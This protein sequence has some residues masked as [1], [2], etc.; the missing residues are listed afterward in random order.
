MEAK[1][2][3]VRLA[4][5]EDIAAYP[6][7]IPLNQPV[8]NP[9]VKQNMTT[10]GT[11]GILT[12]LPVVP[13]RV[14]Q[15][16]TLDAEKEKKDELDILYSK[17]RSNN[18]ADIVK[19]IMDIICSR[20]K[21]KNGLIQNAVMKKRINRSGRAVI[22]PDPCISTQE[23]IIPMYF[24]VHLIVQDGDR[25]RSLRNGDMVFLNRQP[26]LHLGNL[27]AFKVILRNQNVISINPLCC[28]SFNADFDGD[29]MNIFAISKTLTSRIEMYNCLCCKPH[30]LQDLLLA[31]YLYGTSDYKVITEHGFTVTCNRQHFETMVKSGAKG[32]QQ[33]LDRIFDKHG[34][35]NGIPDDKFLKEAVT[36]RVALV[37]SK[38]Q[39]SKPGYLY[40]EMCYFLKDII[41]Q[42][43]NTTRL[44]NRLI[45]FS[46]DGYEPG[47]RVGT[48]AATGICEPATQLTLNTFHRAGMMN[49]EA[50]TI[51]RLSEVVEC[52]KPKKPWTICDN[53]FKLQNKSTEYKIIQDV[54]VQ[55]STIRY[56]SIRYTSIKVTLALRLETRIDITKQDNMELKKNKYIKLQLSTIRYPFVKV[57]VILTVD[58][59]TSGPEQEQVNIQM[60][61]L[62]INNNII[63]AKSSLPF[64]TIQVYVKQ[65]MRQQESQIFFEEN[66]VDKDTTIYHHNLLLK[67]NGKDVNLQ[68]LIYLIDSNDIANVCKCFG[69][70]AAHT[71]IVRELKGKRL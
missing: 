34:F 6:D 61:N 8:Q 14:R 38:M 20:L 37:E 24:A 71:I 35:L 25:H 16:I 29:E 2:I 41:V 68:I 66:S 22:V 43:D 23:I 19:R 65:L 15:T 12:E 46:A 48:L 11:I 55:L 69:I 32:K 40:K 63:Q 18:K 42:Y 36:A 51:E 3:R 44:N 31:K 52:K 53:A 67:P 58:I 10:R 60:D 1:K 33:H 57:A 56:T 50:T 70:E 17:L 62:T 47:T 45:Q 5:Q 26:T 27:L 21:N 28:K 9:Y 13:E 64:N 4:S 54:K 39:T 49:K 59:H 7:R 30:P